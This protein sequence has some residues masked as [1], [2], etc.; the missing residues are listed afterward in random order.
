MVELHGRLTEIAE[1]VD[2]RTKETTIFGV[3]VLSQ[4]S[5]DGEETIVKFF[6][7]PI[8]SS[9]RELWDHLRSEQS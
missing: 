3:P 8:K 1:K 5:V 6:G 2:A 4:Y 7:I 9:R